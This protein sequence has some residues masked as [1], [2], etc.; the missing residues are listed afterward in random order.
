M[1]TEE[2]EEQLIQSIV[3]Q[4]KK[5]QSE[6]NDD[7]ADQ[8]DQPVGISLGHVS[9]SAAPALPVAFRA[10]PVPRA[11]K[12]AADWKDMLSLSVLKPIAVFAI[13]LFVL[14]QPM[15]VDLIRSI[16]PETLGVVGGFL[17]L[18]VLSL[19]ASTLITLINH[20]QLI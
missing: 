19:L 12:A 2:S 15:V 3:E 14:Y 11:P 5:D 20:L 9:A 18:V 6:G 7:S 8:D 1:S 16:I 4:V 13:L 17:P 10:P